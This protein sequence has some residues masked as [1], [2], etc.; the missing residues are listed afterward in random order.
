MR[1]LPGEEENGRRFARSR[2]GM[3][4]TLQ[5]SLRHYWKSLKQGRPGHRFQAHYAESQRQERGRGTCGR[6]AL[7]AAAVVCFAIGVV[8]VFIPG[9]AFVFFFLG[10][11][12]LAS[13]SKFVARIM[14]WSEVK[15]RKLAHWGAATWRRLGPIARAGVLVAAA[16]AGAAAT[17]VTFRWIQG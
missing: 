10:G 2:E 6:L 15:G 4:A 11:G 7:I 17:F 13:E 3:A 5:R 8:L 16:A 12:L 9:P 1:K 14:D